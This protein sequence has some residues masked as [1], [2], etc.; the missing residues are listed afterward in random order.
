M[1]EEEMKECIMGMAAHDATMSSHILT[2]NAIN[3]EK[4]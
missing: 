2:M 1:T 4:L 3:A